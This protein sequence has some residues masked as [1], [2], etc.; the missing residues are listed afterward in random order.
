MDLDKA[1]DLAMRTDYAHDAVGVEINQADAGAFFL[2][3]FLHAEKGEWIKCSDRLPEYCER[4]FCY[5]GKR[6]ETIGYIVERDDLP[7]GRMWN[8]NGSSGGIGTRI[9]VKPPTHWQPLPPPPD[10]S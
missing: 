1:T 4:V 5:D 9:E 2:E 8:I 10:N 6:K 3:G 7:K